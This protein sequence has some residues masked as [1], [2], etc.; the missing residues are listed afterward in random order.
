MESFRVIR[1]SAFRAISPQLFDNIIPLELISALKDQYHF[2]KPDISSV[3]VPVDFQAGKFKWDDRLISIEQFVI[4]FVGVATSLGVSTRESSDASDAFLDSMIEWMSQQYALDI[5]ESFPRA[6]FSQVE[7]V[8]PRPI[9]DHFADLQRV[10]VTIS[11][12]V[13]SYKSAQCP[14][15]EL[16]GFSMNFDVAQNSGLQPMPQ[17]FAIDRRAGSKYEERKY[18]SQAP[19]RTQ[20]HRGVLEQIERILLA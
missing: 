13:R 4:Q 14:V 12:M 11:E 9:S 17:P 5:K 16:S 7:F 20:D 15:Y 19:L 1:A 2:V 18:F 8:L 10:G 6:Y 3:N